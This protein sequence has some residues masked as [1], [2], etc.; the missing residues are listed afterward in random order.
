MTFS[1]TYSNKQHTTPH[2]EENMDKLKQIDRVMGMFLGIA[3]GDALGMP[4][5]KIFTPAELLAMPDEA[6]ADYQDPPAGHKFHGGKLK[7]GETTDDTQLSLAVAESLIACGCIDLDH[8]A[9]AHVA[10][11]EERISGWG[12]GTLSAIQRIKEGV[13]WKESGVLGGAGNGVMMKVS[14]VGAYMMLANGKSFPLNKEM[15]N[16]LDLSL[17]THQSR[18]GMAQG[19]IQAVSVARAMVWDE[20]TESG[21]AQE[22]FRKDFLERA[23]CQCDYIESLYAGQIKDGITDRLTDRLMDLQENRRYEEDLET[24]AARYG[25]RPF[26]VYDSLPLTYACFLKDPDSFQA[27]INAIRVGG[28]TDTNASIVGALLGAK[29]GISVFPSKLIDGL[30][31]KSKILGV[32]ERFCEKFIN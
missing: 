32:A 12:K 30:K 6:F 8:Q 15:Q 10:A 28:D 7:A 1:S 5:E 14:P 13:H 11:M 29:N 23:I 4:F 21:N 31:E 24:L 18:M 2:K 26:Y 20:R 22:D 3:I 19:V 27:V 16:L 17:M 25:E 9:Q